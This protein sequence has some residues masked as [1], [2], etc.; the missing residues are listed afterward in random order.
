MKN[1]KGWKIIRDTYN[2]IIRYQLTD[3]I[4]INRELDNRLD[5]NTYTCVLI[6]NGEI[7]KYTGAG[8]GYRIKDLKELAE[9]YV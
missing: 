4:Y 8:S 1:W 9:K 5:K 2:D 3:N 7:I 6:V